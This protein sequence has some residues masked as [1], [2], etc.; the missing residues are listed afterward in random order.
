MQHAWE[1]W[2]AY[3]VLP[4]NITEKD[5]L[6]LLGVDVSRRLK[7]ISEIIECEDGDRI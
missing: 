7:R 5:N 1:V 3:K 2:S 4:D 6:A